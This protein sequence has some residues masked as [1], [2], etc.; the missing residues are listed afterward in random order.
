MAQD[1]WQLTRGKWH[2]GRGT[3]R[4]TWDKRRWHR[5]FPANSPPPPHSDEST[6]AENLPFLLPLLLPLLAL[7]TSRTGPVLLLDKPLLC[8][9]P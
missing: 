8:S 2:M 9:G 3:R 4:D 5:R 1:T 6:S 7:P